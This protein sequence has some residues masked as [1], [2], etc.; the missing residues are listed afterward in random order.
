[1]DQGID[2]KTF[3]LL[4]EGGVWSSYGFFELETMEFSEDRGRLQVRV[5]PGQPYETSRQLQAEI[6]MRGRNN[7]L[8]N[9]GF[10]VVLPDDAVHPANLLAAKCDVEAQFANVWWDNDPWQRKHP[11]YAM[12]EGTSQMMLHAVEAKYNEATG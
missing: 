7:E 6:R 1:M 3:E 11:W 9:A 5:Q 10:T 12:P 2:N 8:H 4:A